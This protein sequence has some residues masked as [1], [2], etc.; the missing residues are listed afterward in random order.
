MFMDRPLYN[1]VDIIESFFSVAIFLHLNSDNIFQNHSCLKIPLF[2][3]SNYIIDCDT[4]IT[5]LEK[6]AYQQ[7][8]NSLR[9]ESATKNFHIL[10]F[11]ECF[12]YCFILFIYT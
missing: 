10:F 3:T 8:W 7:I 9:T 12:S 4:F 5:K 6:P 2:V 11:L 1:F